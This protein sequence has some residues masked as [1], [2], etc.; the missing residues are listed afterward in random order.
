LIAL[1][2]EWQRAGFPDKLYPGL[3]QTIDVEKVWL[4]VT[5]TQ[6]LK[7]TAPMPVLDC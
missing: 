1:G 3:D 7:M 4:P 6:S 5:S 2:P